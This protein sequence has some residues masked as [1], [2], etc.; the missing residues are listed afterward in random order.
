MTLKNYS[1][2][3][4][5]NSKRSERN[6]NRLENKGKLLRRENASKKFLEELPHS[7]SVAF[8]TESVPEH[9]KMM[10]NHYAMISTMK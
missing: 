2:R 5:T 8:K 3:S 4:K 9:P 6:G 7:S 10:S 1:K